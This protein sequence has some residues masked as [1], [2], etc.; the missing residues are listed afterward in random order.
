MSPRSGIRNKL[1]IESS[2]ITPET[3]NSIAKQ[4]L[5]AGG[6]IVAMPGMYSLTYLEYEIKRT[7]I[8]NRRLLSYGRAH[9]GRAPIAHVHR[10][11]S[12]NISR[13]YQTLRCGSVSQLIH[14]KLLLQF[15]AHSDDHGVLGSQLLISAAKNP[16]KL[17]CS[18]WW[19]TSSL[20]RPWNKWPK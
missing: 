6:E 3:T 7:K 1:F 15:R 2:S 20:W 11:R 5:D 8:A 10:S 19:A 9:N 16:G 13:T 12:S 4:V 18:S 17:L 14:H